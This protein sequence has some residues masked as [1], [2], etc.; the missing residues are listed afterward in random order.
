MK[1]SLEGVRRLDG[2]RKQ[3]R[4][5]EK[6]GSMEGGCRLD[7]GRKQVLCNRLRRRKRPFA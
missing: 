1:G 6:T 7:G 3:A 5:R 2:G 4:W